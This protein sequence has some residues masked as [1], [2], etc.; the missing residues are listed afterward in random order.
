MPSTLLGVR[1]YSTATEHTSK[2]AAKE[3]VVQLAF[4]DRVLDL[5][6]PKGFA[7]GGAAARGGKNAARGAM[8]GKGASRG[9]M[10]GGGRG[11]GFGGQGRGGFGGQPSG[12]NN[13]YPTPPYPSHSPHLSPYF[14]QQQQSPR[15]QPQHNVHLIGPFAPPAGTPPARVQDMV[16]YL[17]DFCRDWMGPS[18][19][20]PGYD[21]RQDPRSES[22]PSHPSAT[23]ADLSDHLS[24]FFPPPSHSSRRF[25]RYS[26]YSPLAILPPSLRPLQLDSLALSFASRSPPTTPTPRPSGS[27]TTSTRVQMHRKQSRGSQ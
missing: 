9:G 12:F 1:K 6:Q 23:L 8:N 19:P 27:T 11:G 5:I 16:G 14:R 17:D 25:S 2:K 4:A 10:S 24:L 18:A 21:V 26:L 20:L 3:A 13:G 7:N 22:S 15:G